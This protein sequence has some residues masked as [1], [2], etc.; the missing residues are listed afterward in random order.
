MHFFPLIEMPEPF[1]SMEF[2]ASES[3]RTMFEGLRR[4]YD[5]I[6]V[7]LPSLAS[8]IDVRAS[9]VMIDAYVLVVEWGKTSTETVQCALA[10]AQGVHHKLL[11]AVL[12]KTDLRLMHHYTPHHTSECY[13]RAPT[14]SSF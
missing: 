12:N 2:M 7:D 5:Y 6:V 4:Q 14:A 10:S 8:V 9:T 3:V 13:F 1:E 11:G